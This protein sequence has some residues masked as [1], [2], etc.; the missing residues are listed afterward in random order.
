MKNLYH[1][2]LLL[3][4]GSPQK[5]LA[6]QIQYLKAENEV[7]RARLPKRI[8]TTVQERTRLAKLGAKL[9]NAIHE[10][11]TIVKPATFLL[12]LR[13]AEKPT[14]AQ[15]VRKGRP[16]TK[17]PIRDL[18]I[19]MAREND[20]GYTRILGELKKLNIK[21]P[22][23]NTIKNILKEN[24]LEPGPKRGEGTWDDFLKRH[25]ATL[26]QCDFYAKRV[27][28]VKGWRD[29][30]LLI[31]LHVESRQVYKC[32]STFHPNEEWVTEQALAFLKHTEAEGMVV[33][34]LM[35]DRDT[36]YQAPFDAAFESAGTEVK[37]GAYR[38][39]NTNAYVERFIQTLQ[40]ECLD[41]FVVFGKEH[42]DYLV[43]EFVDFY[44]EDRPHQGKEN[45]LLTPAE[46]QSEVVSIGSVT[47]RERL[48]GVLKHYHRQA[49]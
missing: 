19:R 48:G 28:T 35:R 49:A 31:F 7:L 14:N 11:V 36:K 43:S 1:N 25:A 33:Q 16:R 29:L 3:I 13:D 30:Y 5:Q 32:P 12:W 18:I 21:P 6:A 15:A 46:S 24:G 2:L 27:L 9:G 41:H 22:S 17:E 26:W 38:S 44:H 47:C 34:T 20:W 45:Q 10:I 4:A 8:V 40:Q 39:P 23:R 42:M 37:V